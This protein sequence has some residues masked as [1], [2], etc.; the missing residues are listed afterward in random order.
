MPVL[1][2]KEYF[3][4]YFLCIVTIPSE[5]SMQNFK[6]RSSTVSEISELMAHSGNKM[7]P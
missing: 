7:I 1:G 4:L 6:N 2:P 3:N 5:M